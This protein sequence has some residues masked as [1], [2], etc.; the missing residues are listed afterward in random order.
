MILK[1]FKEK[2]N[3]N[4]INK[5]L[6]NRVVLATN[7]K[8]KS[9]G[10]IIN[11]DETVDYKKISSLLKTLNVN[12]NNFQ[13]I[14]FTIEKTFEENSNFQCF[15][16]KS[17]GWKGSIKNETLKHFLNREFDILISYYVEAPMYLKLLT[18]VSK[19]RFKVGILQEDERLNDLIIK[20]DIEN[21]KMFEIELL[22]Y[23]SIL[24]KI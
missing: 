5:T 20:T 17:I 21:Y 1:G 23:L 6:N 18:A 14:A 11:A 13:I 8:I 15:N 22:K 7:S 16:K 2:S 19:A 12:P 9:I 3:Q 4:Y 24:N 10:V